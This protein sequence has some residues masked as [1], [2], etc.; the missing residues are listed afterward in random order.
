[1]ASL[2]ELANEQEGHTVLY[3]PQENLT[4]IEVSYH[5]TTFFFSSNFQN[6]IKT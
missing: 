5:S 1:M 4:N 6:N 2:T 3:I